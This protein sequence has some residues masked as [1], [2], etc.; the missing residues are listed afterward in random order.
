MERL[1]E[2]FAR[3]KATWAAL[4]PWQRYSIMG[5][6]ALIFVLLILLI[7]TG[8]GK[9]EPLFTGLEVE[10]QA[11]ILSYLREHNVPYKLDSAAKAVLVPEDMVYEMRLSLAQQGLPRGGVV[12]FEIF[13]QAKMGMTDFQQRVSY[14]RALEGELSRTIG[15]MEAIDFA[16]VTIVIP[17]QRLFLKEQEPSSASVLVGVKRG[18]KVG[19]EQVKAIVHL[20]AHSVQGLHPENITVVDTSGNMLSELIDSDTFVYVDDAGR[21]VSS[22]QR[23]LERRQEM[24]LER[25]V[26]QML[27]QVF[28]PGK[29]VVRVRVEL[30]FDKKR[31]SVTE[32]IPGAGGRGVVRSE[33]A[34][35]ESY[36]GPGTPPGGAPGTTTNIPGYV[37]TAQQVGPSEYNKSDTIRNY[38][39]T[40]REQEQ[41]Y[42]PGSVKR[43]SASVLIDGE[44]AEESL[45]EL[46]STVAAAIGFDEG[47]GDQLVVQAMNFSTSWMDAIMAQLQRERRERMIFFILLIAA[48]A[49]IGIVTFFWWKRRA[50]KPK[51]APERREGA[52]SL[53]ELIERPELMQVRGEAAVI[54][55]QLKEYA[56][57]KPEEIAELVQNWLLED[58]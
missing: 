27:E 28:G 41:V 36:I 42:T 9:Y 39:I 32:Y 11:A 21:A 31:D 51:A 47:R 34:S 44:L 54:E 5:A 1:R 45:G 8:R 55:E 33:Q 18:S 16:R 49:L 10:D 4:S 12:G 19:P 35:E 24:E 30:D 48:I 38:E 17:E 57:Q 20:V 58:V 6:G 37:V 14:I 26:K 25:K 15:R 40:T 3:L 56:K 50:A 22:I 53:R 7:A 13:D 23:E 2:L 29:A 52:P 43:L 46:R